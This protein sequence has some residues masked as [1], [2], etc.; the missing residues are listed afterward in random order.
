MQ[1][2]DVDR[3]IAA[4]LAWLDAVRSGKASITLGKEAIADNHQ[5]KPSQGNPALAKRLADLTGK[6]KPLKSKVIAEKAGLTQAALSMF[7]NGKISLTF[8]NAQKLDEILSQY[9]Q[10]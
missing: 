10:K 2:N 4:V 9:E 7:R 5:G 6:G 8:S 1:L 3:E